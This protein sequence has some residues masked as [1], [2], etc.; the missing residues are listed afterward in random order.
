MN[1]CSCRRRGPSR[2]AFLAVAALLCATP[3]AAQNWL[4]FAREHTE[5]AFAPADSVPALPDPTMTPGAA[6]PAVSLDRIC[7]ETTRHRR[8][9]STKLCD[10]VLA[11]Y[12]IPPGDRYRY[13]CDHLVPVALGGLTVAANLRPQPNLEAERKDR[14]EVEVQRR[15]CVAYRTLQPAEA[16]AVLAQERREI[17]N[18][19]SAAALIYLGADAR[20]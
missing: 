8:L 13:E 11:A 16:A 7:T 5:K 9:A 14:L 19:W 18:D 15:A 10:A 2:A 6:D 3:A 12:S 1:G 4:G 20:R 17:A